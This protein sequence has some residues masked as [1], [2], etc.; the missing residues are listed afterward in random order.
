MKPSRCSGKLWQQFYLRKQQELYAK[1]K[2]LWIWKNTKR[3]GL[4]CIDGQLDKHALKLGVQ[5][6]CAAT[7]LT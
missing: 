4:Q 1:W 7:V 3:N 5:Y 2:Y 6:L